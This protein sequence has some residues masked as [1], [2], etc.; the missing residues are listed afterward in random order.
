MAFHCDTA[1]F[2][3]P[4]SRANA[5]DP[6]ANLI[7]ISFVIRSVYYTMNVPSTKQDMTMDHTNRTLYGVLSQLRQ[8]EDSDITPFVA[9]QLIAS[10]MSLLN[11]AS[12]DVVKATKDPLMDAFM[13]LDELCESEFYKK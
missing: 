3:M 2:V 13:R 7:A 8:I 1:P 9:R 6:P 12:A 10:T 4:N 5:F 11:Q